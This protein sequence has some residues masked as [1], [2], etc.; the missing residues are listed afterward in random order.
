MTRHSISLT[1]AFYNRLHAQCEAQGLSKSSAVEALLQDPP[2]ASDRDRIAQAVR[3]FC[4]IVDAAQEAH[5]A[6]VRG[7]PHAA[8]S[9]FADATPSTLSTLAWWVR[10]FRE[11]L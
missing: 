1:A 9:A 5:L 10:H 8:V 2:P 6:R 11:Q 4:A 7:G 3:E